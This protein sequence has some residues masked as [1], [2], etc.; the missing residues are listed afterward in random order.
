MPAA[1]PG[2]PAAA[3]RAAPPLSQAA[4]P[5]PS[6]DREFINRNQIVERYIGGR[7]PLKG[8]QDFERFCREH[9]Q[10]LDE[11]ALTERINA[12]LRL[13]D[14][15]GRPAPWEQPR[16]RWWEQ[17]P[18]LIGTAL[19]ALALGVTC[20][21]IQ[22]RLSALDRTAAGLR[23]R[24]L[25]QPLEPAQS[26]RSISVIPSRTGPVAHSLVTIGGAQA[27][28]ADLKIDL[29]WSQFS[30]FRVTI[31]RIDQGSVGVL[32]NVLRDSSGNLR[33]ELNSGALGPGDYQFTIEGLTWRGDVVPQAWATVSF[34][35]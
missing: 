34:A 14:A 9:P 31:D 8:A 16:K 33:I 23:Q 11:I 18:V 29:S 12:A 28:T 35:H 20:L 5:A 27:Q 13:L 26:T 25:L 2:K 4:Q 19:L 15:G 7:L 30:A 6:M 10:L 32:H 21:M 3:D 17:L 1:A 24:V 22:G